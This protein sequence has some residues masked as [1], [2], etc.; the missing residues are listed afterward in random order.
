MGIGGNEM[1][2]IINSLELSNGLSANNVY[3]RIDTVNGSKEEITISLNYYV[4]KDSFTQ[5]KSPLKQYH[6][7]FVPSV[8]E[9]SPNFIKQGYEYIKTI[10]EFAESVDA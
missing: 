4:N 6:H 10:P 9:D 5:G 2:L 3:V 8:G 7:S 1:A